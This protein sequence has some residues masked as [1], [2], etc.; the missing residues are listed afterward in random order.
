MKMLVKGLTAAT[1]VAVTVGMMAT[2]SSAETLNQALAAAYE[3]NPTLRA[4]R[5]EQRANDEQVP[6]A[7]S[8]WRPTVTVNGNIGREWTDKPSLLGGDVHA[9]ADPAG[10]SITL[11]QP[12]FSGFKTVEGTRAAESTVAAGQQNLL[13]V[14]QDV[15]F[16]AVQAYMNVIRDRQIVSLRQK[17]VGVLQE[18]LRAANVRLDAGVITRTDVAQVRA[19]LSQS[20]SFLATAQAGLAESMAIYEKIIG[21]KPKTLNYPKIARL[22][23]SLQSAMETASETNPNILAAALVEDASIHTIEVVKGD[24]LPTISLQASAGI[25]DDLS[26]ASNSDVMSGIVQ[27]TISVPLYE[28]GLVYS[29]VR[30]A[31][32]I[33][34]QRRIQVIEAGRAVRANVITAWSAIG[35]LGEAIVSAKAQVAASQLALDGVRQEYEA[36][37]RTTLDVLNAQ[38]ELVLARIEQVIAERNRVVAAYQ[39]LGSMGHLTAQH[40]GLGVEIYDADENYQN[41]RDKWIGTD[42]ETVE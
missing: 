6:Q 3:G 29:Q 23:K 11:S 31:K 1:V 28:G 35:A 22:P 8:G 40:L 18:Q 13:A 41:V 33:A 17:N 42:A 14:E 10:V 30:Q 12:I 19:R 37:S 21:H 2:I 5:A 27:G 9:S 38:S 16:Q 39:L 15:L 4:A 25:F 36:G 32:Q 7:L 20:Q 26:D 24:L 34:S